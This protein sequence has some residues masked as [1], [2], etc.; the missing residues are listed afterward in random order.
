VRFFVAETFRFPY[1]YTKEKWKAEAFRYN[2]LLL[3]L[4]QAVTP[5]STK[6]EAPASL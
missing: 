6:N 3:T 5:D 2:I 1:S 4:Y